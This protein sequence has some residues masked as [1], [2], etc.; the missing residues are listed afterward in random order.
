M[1]LNDL[2]K[3]IIGVV[4]LDLDHLSKVFRRLNIDDFTGI[5]KNIIKKLVKLKENN[6]KFEV[7]LFDLK[8]QE[9]LMECLEKQYTS[10]NLNIYIENYYDAIR[11]EKL[12]NAFKNID[13]KVSTYEDIK[14]KI[15]NTIE[16]NNTTFESKKISMKEAFNE[17]YKETEDIQNN[18][19]IDLGFDKLNQICSF[20]EGDVVLIAGNTGLGKTA[21]GIEMCLRSATQGHKILFV[22]LEMATSQLLTRMIANIARIN[23]NT[24]KKRNRKYLTDEEWGRIGMA[25]SKLLEHIDIFDTSNTDI[26]YI[27]S[28]IKEMNKSK[29]YDYIMIDYLQLMKAEGKS[30]YEII[31]NVSLRVKKLARELKKTVVC[32]A[33]LNRGNVQRQDKKPLLTDLKDSSQLEQDCSIG[34]VLHSEDYHDKENKSNSIIDIEVYV[35]KNRNGSLGKMD[36]RFYKETQSFSE[37]E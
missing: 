29:N 32:L 37:G 12:I 8:E 6:N 22:S 4:L 19:N 14:N 5:Y 35:D 20:D 9:I 31:T 11:K 25:H 34:I 28:E 30:R 10:I 36:C 2:Q 26:N 33:Q 21:F 27:V 24:L 18:K 7:E 1:V 23:I 3:K 13:Y 15:V 17:F 16:Q